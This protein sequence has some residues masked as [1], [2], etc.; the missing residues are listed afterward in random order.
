M[1]NK[2]IT[3]ENVKTLA[4]QLQTLGKRIV[5]AGGCFDILH[6]GHI[7][8]LTNAKKHGD[9]LIILLEHDETITKKKGTNRP[10]NSQKD[11]A[12]IL[13]ELRSIDYIILLPPHPTNTFYDNLVKNIKPAIIA[14]T[15]GNPNRYHMLRQAEATSAQ[16]LDV[17]DE[18][19]DQSTTAIVAL[20]KKGL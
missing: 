16:V 14:T 6:I 5:L 19:V 8:F 4:E 7:A 12:L 20:L 9:I 10:F 18:I 3:I 11:R 13:E 15:K 2:I 1:E 17:T